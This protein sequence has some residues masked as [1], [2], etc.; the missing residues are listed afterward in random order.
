MRH[1]VRLL[2]A[3]EVVLLFPEGTRTPDGRIGQ[4]HA[5]FVMLARR[6]G[7]VLLPCVVEGANEVW[8]RTDKFAHGRRAMVAYCEPIGPAQIARHGAKW[9]AAEVD[10][11]LVAMQCRLRQMHGKP[12]IDYSEGRWTFEQVRRQFENRKRRRS[13][14]TAASG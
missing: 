5:S 3:G 8:G 12:P 2:R 9:A 11:R 10:R 6:S 4:L 14:Q 13:A 1:T 7:A